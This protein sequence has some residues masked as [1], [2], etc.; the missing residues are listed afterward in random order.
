MPRRPLDHDPV[1]GVMG[2][3]DKRIM[4]AQILGHAYVT[5]HNLVLRNRAA[6]DRI[7]AVLVERREFYGDEV[8]QLL[9]EAGL[10]R[11][12][13]DLLDEEAWPKV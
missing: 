8:V 11:P 7:A 5:A 2:D 12:E 10:E 9:E 4:M 13:L 3:R 6:V 1:A